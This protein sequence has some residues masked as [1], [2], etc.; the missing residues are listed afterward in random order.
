MH[1]SGS[2]SVSQPSA[3]AIATPSDSAPLVVPGGECSGVWKIAHDPLSPSA[4]RNS[5]AASGDTTCAHTLIEP[6]DSPN[7]VALPGSPPNA[8]TLLTT[9]APASAAP[10]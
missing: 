9:P 2:G 10:L 6:A 7:A 1:P 4:R 5:P 8:A 3:A